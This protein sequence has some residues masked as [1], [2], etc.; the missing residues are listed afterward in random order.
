MDGA[1][2]LA[3]VLPS[4]G[5]IVNGIPFRDTLYGP[6]FLQANV[7]CQPYGSLPGLF[8]QVVSGRYLPNKMVFFTHP[9]FVTTSS[10][11]PN[12]YPFSLS[13]VYGRYIFHGFSYRYLY[14]PENIPGRHDI[15][16][17]LL[18]D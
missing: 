6:V 17:S 7:H 9:S 13:P 10:H 15:F 18:N 12:F 8:P 2:L 4:E 5:V 14:L 1:V 11:Q 3:P 16:K